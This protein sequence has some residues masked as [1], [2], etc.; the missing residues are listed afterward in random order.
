MPYSIISAVLTQATP[1][2]LADP[3]FT[4]AVAPTVTRL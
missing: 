2:D 3:Y 1:S 4:T